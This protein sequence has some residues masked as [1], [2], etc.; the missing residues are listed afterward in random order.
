MF[1]ADRARPPGTGHAVGAL[2]LRQDD[3]GPVPERPAA[4]AGMDTHVVSLDDFYRGRQQAPRLE[5]GSYDYEALEAL[6]LDQLQTCLRELIDQGRTRIPRFDFVTG[7]PSP[8]RVELA[9]EADP[10]LFLRAST[11]SIL[12]L[13]SICLRSGWRKFMSILLPLYT[14]AIISCWPGAVSAW[15]GAFCGTSV[16]V[17]VPRPIPC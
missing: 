2:L 8:E 10:W 17:T 13:K 12:C 3:H 9:L 11:L 16:S 14:T 4:G 15:Y 7:R 5:D 1:A 6:D